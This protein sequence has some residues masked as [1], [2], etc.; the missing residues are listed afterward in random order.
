MA[1]I[2]FLFI[3][4]VPLV[5]ATRQAVVNVPDEAGWKVGGR[6]QWMHVTVSEQ[7][8]VYAIV[9][10]RGYEQSVVILGAAYA[11]FLVHDGW[12]P[13]DRFLQAFHQRRHCGMN[14]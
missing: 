9:P 8:T 4:A 12:A 6:L 13:Y 3:V 5:E 10:G 11:N 2:Q 7:V 1:L 14:R